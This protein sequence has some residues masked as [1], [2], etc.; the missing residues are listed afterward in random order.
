MFSALASSPFLPQSEP[1]VLRDRTLAVAEERNRNVE[2]ASRALDVAMDRY[3]RG[4][5][6]AFGELYDGLA[7]RLQSFLQRYTR[8]RARAE[9]VVQQ[10]MLQIHRA[11]GRF[12]PGAQ[13]VPWAFAIARRLL[14]DMHRRGGREVLAPTS[15]ETLTQVMAALDDRADDVA[16]A[17]ETAQRLSEELA[18][19]PE[20]QRVAFELIKQDG[21]SVAEAAQVLGTTV[22]A[23]KLRAHRAYEAMRAALVRLAAEDGKKGGRA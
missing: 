7:P 20:N 14:I 6:A 16:I 15:D 12:T 1:R 2:P 21:L 9:D 11:R 23:V 3:A 17:K 19:L 22:A 13:V 4:E 5:D 10:T 18:R 8:D